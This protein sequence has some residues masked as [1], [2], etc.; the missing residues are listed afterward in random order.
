MW[1]ISHLLGSDV[2][3]NLWK[4]LEDPGGACLSPLYTSDWLFQQITPFSNNW[5]AMA[6]DTRPHK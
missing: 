4:D 1:H 5:I 6:Y 3:L 2:S